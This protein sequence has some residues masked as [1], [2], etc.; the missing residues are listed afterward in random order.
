M[1]IDIRHLK[2]FIEF[3][4]RELKLPSLPYIK[5]VGP[6][7]N[8]YD[9]FGHSKGTTIVVRITDRHPIDIMRTL[10]H[11]L[12]HYKQSILGIRTNENKREDQANVV[13]G[14]IMQKFD[15]SHPNVFKDKS[16]RANMLFEHYAA[17][18]EPM[19]INFMFEDM[20]LGSLAANHT[21]TGIN[22]FDPILPL[23]KKKK[24]DEYNLKNLFHRPK[25]RGL[26]KIVKGE[27]KIDK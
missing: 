23:S 7:E 9:A 2:L 14:R 16:V 17:P 1:Q 12:L 20:A 6:I 10:A 25:P 27:M 24:R 5:F 8:K 26:K 15:V 18:L 19:P 3:A 21:G 11:E 13:A 4:K 22:N